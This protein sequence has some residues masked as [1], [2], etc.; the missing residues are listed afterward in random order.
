MKILTKKTSSDNLDKITQKKRK[1]RKKVIARSLLLVAFLL[2]INTFA[3]F[4]YISKVGVTLNGSVVNWDIS[5]LEGTNIIKEIDIDITDMKPGMVPFEKE[6]IINNGGDIDAK[7]TYRIDSLTLLGQELLQ[8]NQ[9]ETIDSIKNNYPFK[10]ELSS[11]SNTIP[12]KG[13][14]RVKIGLKWDYEADEYYKLN[15]LYAYD[16]GVYYYTLMGNTYQVD[17]TVTE[18]NFATKVASGLYLEKDNADSY[19]GY[20]CGKYE[21]STGKSCLH[22]KLVLNVTQAN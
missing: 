1:T 8:D 3:W 17:N 7:L 19:W 13:S 5:F 15:N 22:M 2:A 9:N 12:V 4:T 16:S 11:T 20:S 14:A 10:L 18:E 21:T 6:I